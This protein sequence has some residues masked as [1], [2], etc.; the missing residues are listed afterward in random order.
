MQS[1]VKKYTVTEIQ[2]AKVQFMRLAENSAVEMSRNTL[3]QNEAKASTDRQR[4]CY[5]PM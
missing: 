3:E 2:V 1:A 5:R 4:M